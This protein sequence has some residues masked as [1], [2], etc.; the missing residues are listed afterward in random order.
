MNQYP[1]LSDNENG[2]NNLGQPLINNYH[3]QHNQNFTAPPPNPGN[4]YAPPPNPGMNYA[5]PP[6]PGMNYAPP[7]NPGMNYAPPPNPGMNYAPPPNPGNNFHPHNTP[8]YNSPNPGFSTPVP[9]P[10]PNNIIVI[11]DSNRQPQRV[12]TITIEAPV[13]ANHN[14]PS[15]SVRVQCVNCKSIGY[16]QTRQ[17]ADQ[18]LLVWIIILA[19]LGF[20][21]VFPWFFL[22]CIVPA[23]NNSKVVEHTCARC[24]F[25]LGQ[26][27]NSN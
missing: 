5:P 9:P 4:N 19:G 6:N 2:A 10:Q 16:S 17:I 12:Q 3:P 1:N 15:Y 13:F 14:L 25:L 24:G 21:F 18:G 23:Y 20:F 11:Q 26:Y 27:K 7:P 22:C 8:V